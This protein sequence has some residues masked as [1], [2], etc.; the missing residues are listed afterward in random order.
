MN[1]LKEFFRYHVL[2]LLLLRII[3]LSLLLMMLLMLHP[4]ITWKKLHKGVI[5]SGSR[6]NNATF[7]HRPITKHHSYDIFLCII[8]KYFRNTCIGD[9]FS[10]MIFRTVSN[11]IRYG[12]H[13]SF[14]ITPNTFLSSYFS[15]DM[16]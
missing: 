8:I 13:T 3:V 2:L 6:H 7:Q 9:Y 4:F 12:T 15:H 11:T 10:A 16:M 14:Y 1:M 5:G